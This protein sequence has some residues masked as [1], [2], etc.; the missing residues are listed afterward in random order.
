MAQAKAGKRMTY[1]VTGQAAK[2]GATQ[3]LQECVGE[4]QISKRVKA[5]D[6]Q[7]VAA[8]KQANQ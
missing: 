1:P 5:M 8:T 2:Q 7:M 3:T 4:S 6:R